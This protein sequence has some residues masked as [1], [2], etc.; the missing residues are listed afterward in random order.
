[1]RKKR[2]LNAKGSLVFSSF[3]C[4]CLVFRLI[5]LVKAKFGLKVK[6]APLKVLS[7][8]GGTILHI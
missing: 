6:G 3:Y 8:L 5:N 1:V 4:F 7:Y 2:G